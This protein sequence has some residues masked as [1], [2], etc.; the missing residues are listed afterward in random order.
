MK[1]GVGWDKKV[2]GTGTKRITYNK[3]S[4]QSLSLYIA[5]ES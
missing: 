4:R 3:P 1:I 2:G 5:D